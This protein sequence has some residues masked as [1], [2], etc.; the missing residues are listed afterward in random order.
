VGEKL[1]AKEQL[2]CRGIVLGGKWWHGE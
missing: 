1:E 2:A